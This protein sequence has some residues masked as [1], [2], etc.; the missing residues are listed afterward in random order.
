MRKLYLY[1]KILLLLSVGIAFL[2]KWITRAEEVSTGSLWE[3]ANIKSLYTDHKA[4]N[5]GDVITVLIEEDT[6]AAKMSSSERE[7]ELELNAETKGLLDFIPS[8]SGKGKTAYKGGGATARRGK[9]RGKITAVVTN[10]LPGGNLVIKGERLLLI[11]GE[12][13]SLFLSGIVRTEDIQPDNTILSTYIADAKI[14]YRG[15]IR[16]SDKERPNII[17]RILSAIINF[18]F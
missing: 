12:E 1:F 17:I 6:K 18:L 2:G 5:V 9:I 8:F 13:E 3:K 7:K 16:I 4:Y 11:N 14:E 15:K 10:V